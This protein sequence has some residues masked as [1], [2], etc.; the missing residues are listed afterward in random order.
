MSV[1]GMLELEREG[2]GIAR[3]NGSL[4]NRYVPEVDVHCAL[5]WIGRGLPFLQLAL[6]PGAESMWHLNIVWVV[7]G[8]MDV[9]VVLLSDGTERRRYRLSY[10]GRVGTH[11]LGPPQ[12]GKLQ[13]PVLEKDVGRMTKNL[14]EDSPRDRCI[15][16]FS[17]DR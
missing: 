2:S 12:C 9:G 16:T 17:D 3:V 14:M 6:R 8:V 11:V 1:C 13:C 15:T 4:E 7:V 5:A 10:K